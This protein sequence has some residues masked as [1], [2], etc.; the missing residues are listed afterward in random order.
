MSPSTLPSGAAAAGAGR[1]VAQDLESGGG[2][3]GWIRHPALS[4]ND[5]ADPP[6]L[7]SGMTAAGAAARRRRH[8]R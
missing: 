4:R 3:S 1:S 5:G 6:P 7:L 8:R 2:G